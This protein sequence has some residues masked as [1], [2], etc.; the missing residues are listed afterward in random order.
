MTPGK[1]RCITDV[2]SALAERAPLDTAE[3]WDNV[4]LLIGDPS[5]ETSGAVISIDLTEEAIQLAV[6]R[7]YRLIVNH[8]PCIFP[9]HRGL[10]RVDAQSRVFQAIRHGIGVVA[11]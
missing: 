5:W 1:P 6:E 2:I 8:H 10:S 7:K 4:G 9:K 3:E 11:C